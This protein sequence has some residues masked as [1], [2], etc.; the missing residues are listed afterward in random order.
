LFD[1]RLIDTI[2]SIT[3]MIE[4]R[5]DPSK[6]MTPFQFHFLLCSPQV[7]VS[8]EEATLSAYS[9]RTLDESHFSECTDS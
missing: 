5:T 3:E 1:T 6:L 9:A 4:P 8:S 2:D 7:S